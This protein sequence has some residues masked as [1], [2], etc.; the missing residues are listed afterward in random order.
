M[1]HA[2]G[3]EG[4]PLPPCCS[5][6]ASEP[7]QG[8]SLGFS[9]DHECICPPRVPLVPGAPQGHCSRWSLSS[10][11]SYSECAWQGGLC[12]LC[13]PWPQM[14]CS[15]QAPW[16]GGSLAPPARQCQWAPRGG[17]ESPL[18]SPCCGVKVQ[19][20]PGFLGQVGPLPRELLGRTWEAGLGASPEVSQV[21]SGRASGH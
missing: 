19:E 14:T 6:K 1:S 9:T 16:A 18:F 15:P 3:L 4:R 10:R 17:G 2:E 20:E 8:L 12:S 11:W 13:H 7:G 21:L 5:H